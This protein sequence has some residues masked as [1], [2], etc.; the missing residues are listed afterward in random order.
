MSRE[1][2]KYALVSMKTKIT[3]KNCGK[4]INLP[5]YAI[6]PH[7]HVSNVI[8]CECGQSISFI[9]DEDC[10]CVSKEGLSQHSLA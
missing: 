2:Q 10:W 9:P 6:N 1:N 8:L 3:C 7:S 5:N 4:E